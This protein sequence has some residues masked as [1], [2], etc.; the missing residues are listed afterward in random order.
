MAILESHKKLIHARSKTPLRLMSDIVMILATISLLHLIGSARHRDF[1]LVDS[2]V[3]GSIVLIVWVIN[4]ALLGSYEGSSDISAVEEFRRVAHATVLSFLIT[5]T[6]AY[7]T[8]ASP[9]RSIAFLIP[10][11]GVTLIAVGRSLIRKWDR[12]RKSKGIANSNTLVIGTREYYENLLVEF[13]EVPHLGISLSI[14]IDYPISPQGQLDNHWLNSLIE[15]IDR[16]SI[17]SL[18]IQ[19]SSDTPPSVVSSISWALSERKVQVYVAPTFIN[20]FGPRLEM[21]PHPNLALISLEE[22]TLTFAEKSLK[23]TFDLIVGSIALVFALPVMLVICIIVYIKDPGP[24]FFTQDRIG[25]RGEHFKFIKFRTM[26]VGADKMRQDVLGRPD[27][28]MVSRYKDDPRILPFGK[29][30]RRFSLDELPQLFSVVTGKMSIVG[31]RPLLI[32]EL[33]LLEDEEHRRHLT[34]PGLTG[35]WQIN[36]RKE[37]TWDERISM[38][39][40]YIHQWSIG[41]DISIFLKTFY[42]LA[43][44]HGSY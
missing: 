42:V 7:M 26:V 9:A 21:R 39:L 28:E 15:L 18:I 12:E 27:E 29:V 5:S 3:D 41:L 35:L 37:T 14:Q 22:P 43:T 17:D 23:R 36:G 32:E 30:L 38:D 33:P 44:G 19:A 11:V 34:K 13:G 4:L 8:K 24:I 2:F 1:T 6:I 25:L 16:Q 40:N 20:L 31:P 10:L